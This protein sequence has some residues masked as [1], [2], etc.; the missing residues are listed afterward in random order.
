MGEIACGEEKVGVIASGVE[1]DGAVGYLEVE[2]RCIMMMFEDELLI[3]CQR[4]E[5]VLFH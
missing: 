2:N 4:D 1:D 3:S 5:N